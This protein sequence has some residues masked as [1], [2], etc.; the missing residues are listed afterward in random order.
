MEDTQKHN[1]VTDRIRI[2]LSAASCTTFFVALI[3]TFGNLQGLKW[4]A[5]KSMAAIYLSFAV[6][7]IIYMLYDSIFSYVG[8]VSNR[9]IN[10]KKC[11]SS[12]KSTAFFFYLFGVAGLWNEVARVGNPDYYPVGLNSYSQAYYNTNLLV[13]IGS[14]WVFAYSLMDVISLFER[15]DVLT[16]NGL[17]DE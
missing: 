9:S 7:S 14:F 4:V 12:V 2:V 15:P 6:V 17:D 5:P 11:I 10:S 3:I 13:N 1:V 8:G 16:L